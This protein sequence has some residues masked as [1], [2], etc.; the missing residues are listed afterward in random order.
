M[1]TLSQG[2]RSWCSRW[3]LCPGGAGGRPVA[4]PR[5]SSAVS[6]P[7]PMGLT[8]SHTWCGSDVLQERDQR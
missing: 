8:S 1:F 3:F 7:G 2:Q 4:G 5:A 6:L